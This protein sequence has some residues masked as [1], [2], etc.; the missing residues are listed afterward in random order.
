MRQ[1]ILVF[2]LIAAVYAATYRGIDMR[3]IPV[4]TFVDGERTVSRR[5]ETYP[6]MIRVGG[7]A[8]K[9]SNPDVIQCTNVG[10]D[11]H[12]VNWRCEAQLPKGVELGKFDIVCEGW[13]GPGDMEVV[14]GSCNIEYNL[15]GMPKRDGSHRSQGSDETVTKTTVTRTVNEDNDD[16][17]LFVVVIFIIFVIIIL[18]V[19]CSNCRTSRRS[20]ANHVDEDGEP[21]APP[22]AAFDSGAGTDYNGTYVRTGTGYNQMPQT[23]S[24]R[25]SRARVDHHHHYHGPK[26]SFWSSFMTPRTYGPTVNVVHTAP[27]A[28]PV[29]ATTTTKTTTTTKAKKKDNSPPSSPSH[30][31]TN[32][33]TSRSR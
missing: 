33:G 7:N 26:R 12:N 22:D 11:G 28:R 27:P 15:K 6:K 8:P 17:S 29:R 21:M 3:D 16:G 25:P 32:Y 24:A 18:F 9:S 4:L 19:C 10:N 30:T 31:S 1:T 13:S 5:G 20:H 2:L 23:R 14:A